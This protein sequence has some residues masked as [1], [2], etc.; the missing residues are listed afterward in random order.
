[1]EPSRES[2]LRPIQYRHLNVSQ[3]QIRLLSFESTPSCASLRLSLSYV[4]LNDWKLEYLSFRDQKKPTL[5]TSKLCEA[6]KERSEFTLAT[7]K[8]DID[9]NVARFNWGDYTC[10][11]YA[12]GDCAGKK[13]T[14]FVDGIATSVSKRLEAA[15]WW[16]QSSYECR[17]GMKVWLDALCINQADAIDRGAHVLRVK[18]IFGW[19]FAVT[20]WTKED[21]DLHVLGLS[22]PG[23]RLLLC[24]VVLNQYGKQVLEEI[25]GVKERH[26]GMANEEDDQ[27]RTLVQDVDELVFDQYHYSDSD[28]EDDF[29]FGSL[30]L[31]DL[32]C[33]ELMQM[34]QKKYWSRLWIIQ[35]L[36]VSCMTST[37][38]WRESVFHLSTL[39]TIADILRTHSKAKQA[40][41]SEIWKIIKPGLD[42][43]A[44]SVSDD[45]EHLLD[46]ASIRELRVLAARANCSLPQDRIYAL[47][48]LFPSSVSSIVTIDYNREPTEVIAEF[49]SAVP[50]WMVPPVGDEQSVSIGLEA[51]T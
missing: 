45:T 10:L 39:R 40:S 14:I 25:L 6:W 43:L 48:G 50:Q 51:A 18:D 7:P 2:S 9:T 47:L 41:K 3:N 42:L 8:H 27:I 29:G 31:R 30:H 26:W 1:M 13:S 38:H 28:D 46:D 17:L 36:A 16:I 21:D 19:A 49:T 20:V 34:F 33:V 44:F 15:L 4:S 23:E 5:S 22:P 12:W 35:E 37:V 24:E 32:V 11:S